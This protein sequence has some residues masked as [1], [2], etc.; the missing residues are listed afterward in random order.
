MLEGELHALVDLLDDF[1]AA[2]LLD[3][4]TEASSTEA[5]CTI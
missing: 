5:S 1:L 2:W 4:S 3:S